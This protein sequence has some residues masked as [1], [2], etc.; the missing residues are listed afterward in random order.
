MLNSNSTAKEIAQSLLDFYQDDPTRWTQGAYCRGPDG[1]PSDNKYTAI[2]WCCVGALDRLTIGST[3]S[4]VTYNAYGYCVLT[5]ENE[6]GIALL[7]DWNDSL[8]SFQELSKALEK[9]VGK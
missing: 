5:L 3:H 8:G 9:I 1:K 6:L 7:T 4:R 2:C